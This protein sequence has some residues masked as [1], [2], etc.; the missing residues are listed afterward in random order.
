MR[1]RLPRPRTS[2]WEAFDRMEGPRQARPEELDSIID[3][4]NTTFPN[5]GGRMRARFPLLFNFR[6]LEN[7]WVFVE[8]GRVVSHVGIRLDDIFI[9]GCRARMASVGSV[10]TYE[11]YRGRGFATRA[12]EAAAAKTT[13]DGAS[14]FNISGNRGLYD[15]FGAVKVGR[16]FLYDI[17]AGGAT[18]DGLEFV[19]AGKESLLDLARV[20]ER[21]PVR[22]HRPMEDWQALMEAMLDGSDPIRQRAF[23]VYER[24]EPSAYAVYH[25]QRQGDEQV[26]R[27]IEYAGSRSHIMAALPAVAAAAKVP[28]VELRVPDFD[29][30][31]I[32]AANASGRSPRA[33]YLMHHTIKVSAL[34]TFVRDIKPYIEERIG[35]TGAG[36]LAFQAGPGGTYDV[37]LGEEHFPFAPPA[38]T[39]MVFGR[40]E[41]ID[42]S[43]LGIAGD[44]LARLFPMPLP[45][46]GLNYV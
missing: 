20:H 32:R 36:G 21:E 26:G 35:R 18:A 37:I 34:D 33:D 27:V 41:G 28:A 45:L 19:E 11:E 13:R 6:N 24:G 8:N 25:R 38:F 10:A 39:Q 30:S 9:L 44:V 22:Y 4:V 17:P 14:I 46:P 43:D 2:K 31:L 16:A 23:L 7:L 12:L 15:R 42:T 1:R 5:A 29:P 40:P 3:L